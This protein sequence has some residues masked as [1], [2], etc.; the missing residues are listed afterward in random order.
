MGFQIHT[1]CTAES[2]NSYG[3]C[4]NNLDSFAVLN[5]CN[6]SQDTP[7]L[8]DGNK[9]L[10]AGSI[11]FSIGDFI[12]TYGGEIKLEDRCGDSLNDYLSK[13]RY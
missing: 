1:L 8:G 7:E 6:L 13:I 11:G 9:G 12:C 2:C 3:S 5:Q 4:N 10:F